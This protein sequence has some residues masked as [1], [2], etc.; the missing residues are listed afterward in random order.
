MHRRRLGLS[1]NNYG[2]TWGVDNEIRS[3]GGGAITITGTGGDAGGSG[4][5]NFGVFVQQALTGSGG[6]ISI[7]GTG[8]TERHLNYGILQQ[9]SIIN[10]G[11]GSIT[12]VGTGGGTGSPEN[13]LVINGPIT[14]GTGT[15]PHRHGQRHGDRH[16]Q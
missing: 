13:G 11:T 12:L 1:G 9:A 15:S 6:A 5:G 10:T 3:T 16:R 8:G 7:T 2:V 4:S 14:A